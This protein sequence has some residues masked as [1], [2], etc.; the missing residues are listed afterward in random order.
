MR[1][2]EKGGRSSGGN[3]RVGESREKRRDSHEGKRE[4]AKKQ[5]LDRQEA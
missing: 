5:L 2:S 3:G 1:A 4:I